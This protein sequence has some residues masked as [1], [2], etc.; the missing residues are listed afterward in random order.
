MFMRDYSLKITCTTKLFTNKLGRGQVA[1]TEKTNRR[2]RIL[3][4]PFAPPKWPT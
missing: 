1:S 3:K 4:R 2:F